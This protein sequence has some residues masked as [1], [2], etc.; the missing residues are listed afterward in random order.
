MKAQYALAAIE[1]DQM[2]PVFC[3]ADI[4]E[5]GMLAGYDLFDQILALYLSFCLQ[6]EYH[7][8][9][10]HPEDG[11]SASQSSS[12]P[13]EGQHLRFRAMISPARDRARQASWCSKPIT[14]AR[15]MMSRGER[16]S[17][18]DLGPTVSRRRRSNLRASCRF[19]PSDS[20][21][22]ERCRP[23]RRKNGP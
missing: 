3:A 18:W 13:G 10:P 19:R 4:A 2:E 16:R 11:Q 8:S 20:S 17:R 23:D 9:P 14:S 7:I 15:A 12:T 5:E 6:L 1:G 21:H 22:L